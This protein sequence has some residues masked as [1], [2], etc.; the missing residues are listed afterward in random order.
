M[1][2]EL[3]VPIVLSKGETIYDFFE[4]DTL[5]TPYWTILLVT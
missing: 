5:P 1:Q 4:F 2:N 3:I